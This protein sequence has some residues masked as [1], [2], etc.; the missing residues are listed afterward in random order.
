MS[1]GSMDYLCYQ[2]E[3]ANFDEYT[4]LRKAFRQH[5]GLV[6]EALRAVEWVDSGDWG[7]GDEDAAIRAVISREDELSA[8]MKGVEENM[9]ALIEAWQTLTQ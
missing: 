8:A 4:P 7:P 5:L 6:A 3:D 9:A 2:V 1:G